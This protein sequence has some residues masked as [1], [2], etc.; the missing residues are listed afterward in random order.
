MAVGRPR[1]FDKEEALDR[2]LQVFLRRGYEGASLA[3]LTDAMGINPPSLYAAFGNKEALFRQALDRYTASF[4]DVTKTAM[5]APSAREATELF[6]RGTIDSQTRRNGQGCLLVHGALTC[7]ESSDPIKRELLARRSENEEML[8]ERYDR[9]VQDGDLPA[10]TDTA[11][12][13]RYVATVLQGTAVQAAGGVAREALYDLI[14]ITL[15]A[16]PPS[17]PRKKKG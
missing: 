14:E 4:E 13:A 2:A 16:F 9:A 6:M 7:A 1:A 5:Q 11:A 10:N 17:P 15:R 12:L 3:E 8:R